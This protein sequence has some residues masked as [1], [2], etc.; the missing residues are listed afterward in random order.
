MS[1]LPNIFHNNEKFITN[2]KTSYVNYNKSNMYTEKEKII[3]Y[4]NKEIVVTLK[5]GKIIKGTLISKR[6]DYIL[7]DTNNYINIKDI[8][9]IK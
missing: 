1:K 8:L 5:S 6:N 7:L 4:F 9:S 2:N 3:N